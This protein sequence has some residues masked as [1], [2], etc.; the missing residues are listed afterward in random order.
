MLVEGKMKAISTVAAVAAFLAI[1]LTAP[2]P[3][4]ANWLDSAKELL[5]RSLGDNGGQSLGQSEIIAGLREALQVGTERVVAQLGI[6]DGFNADPKVH[7]PLPETLQT[8]Q[9]TL[10]RFGLSGYADE[11]ELRLNRAAE[12]AVPEAKQLFWKAI[13]E[14]TLDDAQAI[15]RGP[16]DAATRYFQGKMSGPLSDRM[17]PV[18]ERT[19]NEVG[20]VSAYDTMMGEYK[21]LPFVPD[22]K[23]DLT[24][25]ALGRAM[26]GLFLYIAEEEARI[27]ND[28]AARTTALLKKLFER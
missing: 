24:E 22:I 27:R 9:Q 28:P 15:Y 11:L 26:E 1:P 10:R 25:H 12:Q 6:N 14:M 16:D 4:S 23:A 20:A 19:L 17:R 21:A 2:C 13:S 7:I 5:Q 18:V 3:A 8:V